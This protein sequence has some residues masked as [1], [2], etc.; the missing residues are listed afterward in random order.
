MDQ[1]HN[2]LTKGIVSSM[3]ELLSIHDTFTTN[4]SQNVAK[5]SKKFA[6]YMGMNDK[7]ITKIY[8]AGLVHDIGKIL[9]PREIL[10]KVGSLNYDDYME[11]QKHSI[12]AYK[13]LIQAEMSEDIAKAV[14][15]HHERWD[16]C[17]YPDGLKKDDIPIMAR[18]LAIVD[19]YDA[20]VNDR[21]YREGY[22]HKLAIEEI[23]ANIGTKYDPYLA[24]EFIKMLKKQ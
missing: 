10:I 2:D 12:Y 6:K 1:L 24:S 17:G 20:M 7:M 16:G 3:L 21:A 19:S 13:A 5:L 23:F 9:I 22:G 14:R 18:M 15:A 8:Y 11:V 4:H